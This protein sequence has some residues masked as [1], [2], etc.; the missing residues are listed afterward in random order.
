[1]VQGC[2]PFMGELV[3][4]VRFFRLWE[5]GLYGI[6]GLFGVACSEL[7]EPKKGPKMAIPAR[8]CGIEARVPTI[9]D[10]NRDSR[11]AKELLNNEAGTICRYYMYGKAKC[12]FAGNRSRRANI[13]ESLSPRSRWACQPYI[14]AEIHCSVA[15]DSLV[16]RQ[17]DTHC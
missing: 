5:I 2:Q 6:G 8:S 1:M 9:L 16:L 4:L 7:P 17:C 3:R 12:R 14:R 10:E 15:P 11:A 13:D